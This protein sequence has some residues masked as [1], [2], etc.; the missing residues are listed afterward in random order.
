MSAISTPLVN[1]PSQLRSLN[2]LRDLPV[3][4]DLV[5]L[6]F[7]E[8]LDA[9]GHTYI[10][11]MRR[12][13]HD[14]AFLRW[15]STAIETVSM[16]LSGYVWEESGR[17]IGNVSLIP[18]I[19]GRQKVY[20]IANVV[21][22][23]DHHRKGI[24]RALTAVAM[25]HAQ[26]RQATAIWLHVRSENTGAI[27]LY[28]QL[29]FREIVHRTSWKAAPDRN[30]GT[31][32]SDIIIADRKRHDWPIQRA[33]LQRLYPAELDWYQPVP[34]N[35]LQPG[36]LSILN[37]LFGE[38]EVR[39]WAAYSAGH[40]AGVLA[41]RPAPGRADQLWAALP[42]QGYEAGLTSLLMEARRSLVW[43]KN[44]SLDFPAGEAAGSITAAGFHPGRTLTWMRYFAPFVE[45][46]RTQK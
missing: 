9:E 29:G 8:M 39:Q 15:A 4:A 14:N 38:F 33:W 25:E 5:E 6:G 11:Q 12:A 36:M 10:D 13:G 2:I 3:V 41:W 44:L 21:V 45:K 20:L 16:P 35:V 27:S 46:T 23:P 7:G 18:F 19:S 24:G 40:L 30:A 42:P 43:R 17:V 22:H 32:G 31:Q 37:R 28:R 26:Q 1:Q 34:W